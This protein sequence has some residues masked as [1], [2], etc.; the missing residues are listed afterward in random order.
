MVTSDRLFND[1]VEAI[2]RIG[3]GLDDRA[4]DIR[5]DAKARCCCCDLLRQKCS[6]RYPLRD[7]GH[8]LAEWITPLAYLMESCHGGERSLFPDHRPQG[9]GCKQFGQRLQGGVVGFDQV[10]GCGD[11]GV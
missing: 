5:A 11:A 3:C 1:G 9:P 2:E 6:Q 4:W 7:G 10:E 8:E